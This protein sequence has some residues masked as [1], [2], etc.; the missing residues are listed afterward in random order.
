MCR[1]MLARPILFYLYV[2]FTR[3]PIC[4]KRKKNSIRKKVDVDHLMEKW[5]G[6]QKHIDTILLNFK[7][8]CMFYVHSFFR[9]CN[10]YY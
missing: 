8:N 7:I 1:H 4:Q 9:L 3:T 10:K 6:P 2:R 5:M